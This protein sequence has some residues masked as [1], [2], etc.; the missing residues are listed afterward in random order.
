ME[1]LGTGDIAQSGNSC[2]IPAKLQ[3]EPKGEMRG[4]NRSKV[5]RAK[6]RGAGRNEGREQIGRDKPARRKA[7]AKDGA[8]ERAGDT[9]G[10]GAGVS[11]DDDDLGALSNEPKS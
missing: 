5:P 7:Y 2:Q 8:G 9:G 4:H 10:G 3:Q 11:A 6:E 1:E